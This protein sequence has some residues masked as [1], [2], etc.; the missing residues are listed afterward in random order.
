MRLR[1]RYRT[2]KSKIHFLA[3]A[4]FLSFCQKS[5]FVSFRACLGLHLRN[6]AFESKINFE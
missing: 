1:L 6:K 5:V 2:F 4:L 3:K